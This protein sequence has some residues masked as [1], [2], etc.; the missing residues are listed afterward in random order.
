[1]DGLPEAYG[2]IE[3]R[4]AALLGETEAMVG[5]QLQRVEQGMG[6]GVRSSPRACGRRRL[7]TRRQDTIKRDAA[8]EEQRRKIVHG[9]QGFLALEPH[10][11]P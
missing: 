8:G 1:V 5:R 7:S 2:G 9:L 11:K 3:R 10:H 6:R 4:E